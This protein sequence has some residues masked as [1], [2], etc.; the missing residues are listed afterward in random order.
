MLCGCALSVPATPVVQESLQEVAIVCTTAGTL[1]GGV[2]F[3]TDVSSVTCQNELD[4]PLSTLSSLSQR[5]HAGEGDP[6]F[7]LKVRLLERLPQA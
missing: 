7:W 6:P 5:P 3:V 4:V 2:V 1:A